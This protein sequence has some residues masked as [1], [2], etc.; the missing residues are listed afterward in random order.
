MTHRHVI[1]TGM[2]P[3]IVLLAL[4]YAVI[5]G[6]LVVGGYLFIGRSRTGPPTV[7][8]PPS[9]P[10]DLAAVAETVRATV[11]AEMLRTAQVALDANSQRTNDLFD[12]RAATVTQETKNLLDPVSHEMQQLRQLLDQMRTSFDQDQGA[13]REATESLTQRLTQLTASTQALDGA[14][15][16]STARGSWGEQQLRNVVELAGMTP[17]ADYAEQVSATTADG[18]R[19]Q[20]P[21][22]VVRLPHGAFLAVDAKAPMAAYLRAQ[23]TA[24]PAE[25]D[26]AMR[27]HARAI[28]EHVRQLAARRYWEQFPE[29]PDFVVLFVPGESFLAEAL[30]AD[31]TLL[32]DAMRSRVL[33]A[34]PVNL[35]ALLLAVAKGWQAFRLAEHTDQVAAIGQELYERVGTV[36]AAV[37][38]MGRGL[39]Q[40]TRGYN[41]L[42]GSLERRVLVSLR[43]FRE[44]GVTSDDLPEVHHLQQARR[45]LSA[46]ELQGVEVAPTS[47]A[48][49]VPALDAQA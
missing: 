48:P 21:D 42:V 29:A 49:E 6:V 15:R 24:D 5:L 16:S 25:R 43:R 44:L 47:V 26:A 17:Y 38:S 8:P 28:R 14:L 45:E 39:D 13:V 23:E 3:V 12:A 34:S 32:D 10:L 27:Q 35:L 2:D 37:T 20:R 31:A 7:P 11:Q 1:L 19:L 41:N 18:E 36:L 33:V 9:P 30:R 22:V 40:A 4:L 46:P